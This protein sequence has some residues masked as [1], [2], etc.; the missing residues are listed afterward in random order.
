LLIVNINNLSACYETIDYNLAYFT[1]QLQEMK[2]ELSSYKAK[3]RVT[4]ESSSLNSAGSMSSSNSTLPSSANNGGSSHGRIRLNVS[5]NSSNSLSST[6]INN[7][8]YPNDADS[9]M[10]SLQIGSSSLNRIP[11]KLRTKKSPKTP[12]GSS[13]SIFSPNPE[14]SKSSAAPT[15][16]PTLTDKQEQILKNA[17][18]LY[19]HKPAVKSSQKTSNSSS[20]S[21]WGFLG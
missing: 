15:K 11:T 8:G 3:L 5:S 12:S 2:L 17:M 19:G 7:S 18:E 10:S 4:E 1:R 6:T 16:T 14:S 20:S 9:M 13:S 21:G